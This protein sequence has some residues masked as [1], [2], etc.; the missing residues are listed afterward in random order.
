MLRAVPSTIR[1]AASIEAA[2]RSG[3]FNCAISRTLSLDNVP[4]F[5]LFGFP[6]AVSLLQAF[7][8]YTAAGGVFR[9]KVKERS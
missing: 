9:I 5:F 3:I 8:S 6:D 7:F 4:T 2:F 1:I